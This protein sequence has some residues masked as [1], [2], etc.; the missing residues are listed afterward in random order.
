MIV[1]LLD[2]FRVVHNYIDITKEKQMVNGKEVNV[3]M[4]PA[5]RLGLAEAPIDYQDVIYFE[6]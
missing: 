6:G 4:T 3:K 5:M 2:I 1:K